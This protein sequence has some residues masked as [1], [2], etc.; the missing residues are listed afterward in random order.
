[1]RG[2][3]YLWAA[4]FRGSSANA[5][6]PTNRESSEAQDVSHP[7]AIVDD[8]RPVCRWSG[9]R[10]P[11]IVTDGTL[12][13]RA[14]VGVLPAQRRSRSHEGLHRHLG[15]AGDGF[16]TITES[17]I[18]QIEVGSTV[19]YQQAAGATSLDSD[20]II[21][22]PLSGNRVGVHGKRVASGH[23]E[24]AFETFLGHCE[25]SGEKG[26]LKGLQAS[27]DVTCV[28]SVCGLEGTYSF[29]RRD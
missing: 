22:A 21:H 6:P 17:S 12:G 3:A 27:V 24:L 18:E 28:G 26:Q 19:V 8:S 29:S 9:V 1:M 15:R 7:E 16:C 11:V 20:V 23:C 10:R 4:M 2:A 5:S 25:L 14:V 13:L